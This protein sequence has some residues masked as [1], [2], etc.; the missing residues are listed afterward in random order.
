MDGRET[1]G[2]AV[3]GTLS[4]VVITTLVG[5]GGIGFETGGC[6]TTT[7]V[8]APHPPPVDGWLLGAAA[9][10]A[11]GAAETAVGI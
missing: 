10:G 2:G 8:L 9:G 6:L 11:T 4:D 5:A 3:V 1:M 7:D